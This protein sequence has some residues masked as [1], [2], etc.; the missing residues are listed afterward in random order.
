MPLHS[1]K[2]TKPLTLEEAIALKAKRMKTVY[3]HFQKL[4]GKRNETVIFFRPDA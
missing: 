1:D 4:G 2:R 3:K